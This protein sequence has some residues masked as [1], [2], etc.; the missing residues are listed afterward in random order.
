MK[1]FEILWELPKCDTETPSEPVLLEKMMPTDLLDTRLSQIFN[2]YKQQQTIKTVCAKHNKTRYAFIRSFSHLYITNKSWQLYYCW[3]CI[4]CQLKFIFIVVYKCYHCSKFILSLEWPM[5][6]LFFQFYY[7]LF[8][9]L[10][11]TMK[12]TENR[13]ELWLHMSVLRTL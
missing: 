10:I 1:G 3:S 11:G 7:F 4:W 2:L 9:K 13:H 6:L 8:K 5:L 12:V